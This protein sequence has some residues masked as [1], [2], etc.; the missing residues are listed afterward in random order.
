MTAMITAEEEG[1][2]LSDQQV[3]MTSMTFLTAGFES[4]NN[5]FTNLAF[6]LHLHPHVLA[7]VKKDLSLVAFMV[8]EAMRW[9]AAAQGFVR[10]PKVDVELHGKTIPTGAQ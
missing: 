4:T 2:Q 10:S 3:V 5:L 7:E 8:E 1:R 6:A 9:D